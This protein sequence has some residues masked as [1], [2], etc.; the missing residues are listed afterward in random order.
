MIIF[1]RLECNNEI[2]YFGVS[3]KFD[4]MGLEGAFFCV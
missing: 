2:N 1:K 4:T 3:F